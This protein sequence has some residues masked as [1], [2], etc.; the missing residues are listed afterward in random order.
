MA[1]VVVIIEG[2]VCAWGEMNE[3]HGDEAIPEIIRSL[4]A[5]TNAHL[6]MSAANGLL[7]LGYG[8]DTSKQVIFDSRSSVKGNVVFDT[9]RAVIQGIRE[10]LEHGLNVED[11]TAHSSLAPALAHGLCY[12]NTCTTLS[13]ALPTNSIATTETKASK[14]NRVLIVS[15]RDEIVTEHSQLMNL[16]FTANKYGYC[17]DVVALD[18]PS[19]LLQQAADITGGLCLRVSK[20]DE[21]LKALMTHILCPTS[22]RTSFSSPPEG[23]VDYRAACIC[24]NRLVNQAWICSVCLAIMCQFM[25]I[26]KVCKA[27]FPL[28]PQKPKKRP[29][30]A[31]GGLA[32]KKPMLK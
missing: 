22:L 7:I 6:S 27:V 8:V 4:V 30:T 15:M 1:S 24:H 12:L 26:C 28:P 9:S 32:K 31:A 3:A 25:P 11:S 13:E 23:T 14:D 18:N 29:S 10:I 16:F 2:S 21:L 5:F 17:V 20:P 19:P